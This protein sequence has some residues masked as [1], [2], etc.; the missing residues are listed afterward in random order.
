MT[1]PLPQNPRRQGLQ[2]GQG[3]DALPGRV[4]AGAHAD[5][6][7]DQKAT[8]TAVS[9]WPIRKDTATTTVSMMFIGVS[10]CLAAICQAV[11]RGAAG[12]TLAPNSAVRQVTLPSVK[13]VARSVVSSQP[14][15]PRVL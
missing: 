15:Q 4:L 5:V 9:V 1:R 3:G 2:Q 12:R 10:H 11:G 14:P 8:S 7:D 6:E 13:P